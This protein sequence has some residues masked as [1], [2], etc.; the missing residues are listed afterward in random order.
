MSKNLDYLKDAIDDSLEMI[1]CADAMKDINKKSAEYARQF[2]KKLLYESM[3]L[4]PDLD[5]HSN[6]N[7]IIVF[8]TQEAKLSLIFLPSGEYCWAIAFRHSFRKV[9]MRIG[10]INYIPPTLYYLLQ[11]FERE[12]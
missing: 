5:L 12:R 7:V 10:D 3:N 4:T 8:S 1:D 11:W 9:R 2:L 6:G